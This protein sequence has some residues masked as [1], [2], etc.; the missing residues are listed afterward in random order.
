[1]STFSISLLS[2][3]S[4]VCSCIPC[5]QMELVGDLLLQSKTRHSY[6]LSTVVRRL[7]WSAGQ[8]VATPTARRYETSGATSSPVAKSVRT[9]KTSS[10]GFYSTLPS[11]A[12]KTASCHS[13][14]TLRTD[15]RAQPPDARGLLRDQTASR[16]PSV[17]RTP[18]SS[19]RSTVRGVWTTCP[20]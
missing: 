6:K 18:R 4:W 8:P 20:R 3:F 15:W 12:T 19:S 1:M 11:A 7:V 10:G 16:V 2:V 17:P 5:I 9:A 13:A 14:P